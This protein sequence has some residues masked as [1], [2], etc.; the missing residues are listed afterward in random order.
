MGAINAAMVIAIAPASGG[1][2]NP[3]RAFGPLFVLNEV[4][5]S[6]QMI[7]SLMPFLG[8]YVASFLY[9]KLLISE[10]LEDELDEL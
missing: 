5:S 9:Q 2:L 6:N 10:E 4:K 3:A 1:M 8:C 7:I